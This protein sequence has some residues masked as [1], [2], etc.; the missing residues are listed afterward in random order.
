VFGTL[1]PHRC[2]LADDEYHH[3]RTYY[4]GLCQSLGRSAGPLARAALSRDA[5]LLAIVADGLAEEPSAPDRC[6]CPIMPLARRDSRSPDSAAMGFASGMQLLLGDQKLA[7]RA[8]DGRRSAKL[9]RRVVAGPVARART[10]L[11]EMGIP[12]DRLEGFEERQA[13]VERCETV[14]P[15][16]AAEPTAEALALV[17]GSIADLPTS[18]PEART[19]EARDDLRDLGRAL[20]RAIYLIDALEDLERDRRRGEFNPCLISGP[21]GVA[22]S[23]PRLRSCCRILDEDL[24]LLRER[25]DRLPWRRN[26]TLVDNILADRLRSTAARAAAE[27]RAVACPGA[28]RPAPRAVSGPIWVR[29]AAAITVAA[30]AVAGW[31]PSA[32]AAVGGARRGLLGWLARV[33]V[34]AAG[35]LGNRLDPQA[36]GKTGGGS[37]RRSRRKDEDEDEDTGPGKDEAADGG[38]EEVEGQGSGEPAE[39]AGSGAD[40]VPEGDGTG[41]GADGVSPGESFGDLCDACGESCNCCGSCGDSCSGMCNDCGSCDK[42]CEGWCDS[43]CDECCDCDQCCNECGGCDQCCDGCNDCNC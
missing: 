22:I 23:R 10:T 32:A 12:V 30:I 8:M 20:G 15:R 14:T 11:V 27:A 31:A 26:R 28:P 2:T 13:A 35:A 34:G 36:D 33:V 17:F 1:N 21:D 18:S 43:C 6:R 4:C 7:D 29:A 37:R 41:G 24:A 5:V 25:V 9:A 42:V 39:A 40:E 19:A 3:Y 38:G 16:A